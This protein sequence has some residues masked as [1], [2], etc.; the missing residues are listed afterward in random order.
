MIYNTIRLADYRSS[1]YN[2]IAVVNKSHYNDRIFN[3]ND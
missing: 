2:P 1:N 3:R